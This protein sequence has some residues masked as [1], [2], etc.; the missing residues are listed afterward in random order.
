MMSGDPLFP[1]ES[2][3][4]QL[5]QI[6]QTLGPLS[7]KHRQIVSKNP[8]FSGLN[9]PR[10]TNVAT[11]GLSSRFNSWSTESLAFLKHCLQMEPEKRPSCDSLLGSVLFTHDNFHLSFPVQLQA[12]LQQEFGNHQAKK[13]NGQNYRKNPPKVVGGAEDELTKIKKEILTSQVARRKQNSDAFDVLLGQDLGSKNSLFAGIYS[14]SK[15]NNST[16]QE[17]PKGHGKIVAPPPT[18][19]ADMGS[20]NRGLSSA[21]SEM[22]SNSSPTKTRMGFQSPMEPPTSPQKL[23]RFEGFEQGL[24]TLSQTANLHPKGAPYKLSDPTGMFGSSR[25]RSPPLKKTKRKET[26]PPH[27]PHHLNPLH[28][29]EES[30]QQRFSFLGKISGNSNRTKI[31]IIRPLYFSERAFDRHFQLDESLT[32]RGE[33]A[34]TST[35]PAPT[36]TS[37]A[38]FG[39]TETIL[40]R[41]GKGRV[42]ATGPISLPS[43]AGA[44]HQQDGKSHSGQKKSWKPHPPTSGATTTTT[45]LLDP[46]ISVG[47]PESSSSPAL[48]NLPFV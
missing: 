23:R 37:L 38:M 26:Y 29:G 14:P 40:P 3:I 31:P 22:S 25:N 32:P 36:P 41:R 5:F 42:S 47:E 46:K 28:L 10:S 11:G 20:S 44:K 16:T 19:T 7:P 27:P 33:M 17:D 43:V 21:K 24:N 18:L 9:A 30:E 8:M 12:K 1:G 45:V 35:P 2:D 39:P 15:T 4:D 13:K 6:T 34:S 48:S